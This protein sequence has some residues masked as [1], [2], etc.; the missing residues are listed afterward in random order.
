M[1]E[2]FDNTQEKKNTKRKIPKKIK[3]LLDRKSKVSKKILKRNNL[4]TMKK[5]KDEFI[6]LEY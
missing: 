6:Q 3:V 2:V 4:S 5:Y 1:K